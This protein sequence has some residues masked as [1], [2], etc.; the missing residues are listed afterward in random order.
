MR[1]SK[2]EMRETWRVILGGKGGKVVEVWDNDDV[3]VSGV[4]G[5]VDNGF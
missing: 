2:R 4:G 1:E 3:G 5:G